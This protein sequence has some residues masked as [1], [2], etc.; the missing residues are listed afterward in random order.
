MG[1]DIL[2]HDLSVVRCEMCFY[3]V[4]VDTRIVVTDEEVITMT[5]TIEEVITMVT[6]KITVVT[7]TITVV[8]KDMAVVVITKVVTMTTEVMEDIGI[9]NKDDRKEIEMFVVMVLL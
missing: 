7:G 3:N 8:T 1:T 6:E 2:S 5:T 4:G 9:E